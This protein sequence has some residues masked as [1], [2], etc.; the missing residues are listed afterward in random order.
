MRARYEET[1]LGRQE[2]YGELVEDVEGALW[3]RSWLDRD[4]VAEVPYPGL[5]RALCALDPAD[6][7]SEGGEQAIYVAGIG[8]NHDLYVVC[9]EGMRTTPLGWLKRAIGLAQK[10]QAVIVYERNFSGAFG[11]TVFGAG[12]ARARRACPLQG[13]RR[14]AGKAH[15]RRARGRPLRAGPSPPRRALPSARGAACDLDRRSPGRGPRTASTRWC[16]RC[17]SSRAIRSPLR[18]E[19]EWRST[20]PTSAG[21][22]GWLATSPIFGGRRGGAVEVSRQTLMDPTDRLRAV[23]PNAGPRKVDRPC[24]KGAR[25]NQGESVTHPLQS[26]T[27]SRPRGSVSVTLTHP[28]F[29]TGRAE[30]PSAWMVRFHRAP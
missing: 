3:K 20:R 8:W 2:L 11:T 10:H 23:C 27:S 30:Q 1:R 21:S 17:G 4:R 24:R 14:L 12:D 29:K 18:P 15:A 25:L 6:G 13:G 22:R 28:V 19:T 16:G 26:R 9:C 7:T 5:R